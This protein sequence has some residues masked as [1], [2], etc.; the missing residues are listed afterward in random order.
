MIE[1]DVYGFFS[2][3]P[4]T[5]VTHKVFKRRRS[6]GTAAT[7]AID[8]SG[9]AIPGA[10][11]NLDGT[12]TFIRR[13]DLVITPAYKIG[14]PTYLADRDARISREARQRMFSRID[15]SDPC[16]LI[17]TNSTREKIEVESEWATD[18]SLY[19]AH[20][21]SDYISN[22]SFAQGVLWLGRYGANAMEID[23]VRWAEMNRRSSALDELARLDQEAGL[24]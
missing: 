17:N 13:A 6:H 21:D 4:W 19:S 24:I 3:H 22:G 15:L 12:M 2:F 1:A 5:A 23:P 10:V 9:P 8:G 14:P 16:R 11:I 7:V 18:P 20:L